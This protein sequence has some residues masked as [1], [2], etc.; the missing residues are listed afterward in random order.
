[1]K[2]P[3]PLTEG[4]L[5]QRYKRFFADVR[6]RDGA[7]VTAHCANSGSMMGVKEPGSKVWLSPSPNPKTKLAWR[8]E[9]IDVEG[10]KVGINTMHPNRIAAEAIA[11]KRIPELA[12]YASAR[13]EVRYG[14]NSRIDLLLEDP[15][16]CFVEVKNVT[17]KRGKQAQFPDAVTER[18]TKH[19]HELA[20]EAKKGNRAVMLYLAQRADCD[21]FSIAEDIDPEYAKTLSKAL[22]SGVEALCYQCALSDTE[23]C[24][25]RPLKMKI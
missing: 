16:L 11:E 15:G 4:V 7:V 9:M 12:G 5:I 18:G 1:M 17:L 25:D 13:R 2:F 23:I 14:Q 22:K 6:L 8:W 10:A 20:N 3:T 21:A 19:L 24:L